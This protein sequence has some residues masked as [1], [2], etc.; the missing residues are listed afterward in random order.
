VRESAGIR[1]LRRI[2]LVFFS[3]LVGV[4]LYVMV[5]T[6]LLPLADVEAPFRWLPERLTVRPYVDMWQDVPLARFLLT[7][8]VVAVAATA[9]ALLVAVPAGYAVA[10][11]RF[12]GRRAFLI[13]LLAVQAAPALLF[14]VPLFV[15]YAAL[16]DRFGLELIGTVPGLVLADLGLTLPLAVW[17]L[18]TQLAAYPRDIEEAARIDGAGTLRLVWHVVVPAA[19]PS[20]AVTGVLAFMMAWGEVLLASVLTDDGTKT[21]AVGLH[22]YVT[23]SGALWNELTAAAL[24]AALPALFGVFA[25]RRSVGRL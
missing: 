18:A 6:S 7:S 11:G 21:V 16:G 4:P 25:V 2:G 12:V 19:A 24:I 13:L 15:V 10:R 9:L 1:W 23:Q 14:L 8:A 22:S 5:T 20:V 3:G 17:L